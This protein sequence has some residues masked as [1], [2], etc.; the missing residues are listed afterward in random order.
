MVLVP[1]SGIR[2]NHPPSL[3]RTFVSDAVSAGRLVMSSGAIHLRIHRRDTPGRYLCTAVDESSS[4]R[5]N[6]ADAIAAAVDWHDAV[7][8][9]TIARHGGYVFASSDDGL[10]AAFPTA[11]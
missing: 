9:Q 7:G 6:G 2:T 3:S 8:R 5:Q 4:R 10:A 1:P 11:A